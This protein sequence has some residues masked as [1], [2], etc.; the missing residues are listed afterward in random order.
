MKLYNYWRSSCSWRVRIALAY[1]NID[2]EYVAVHLVQAG[3]EQYGA[4]YRAINPMAEVP[5]LVFREGNRQRVLSQSL[6]IIEYLEEAY[7][8]PALLPSDPFDRATVRQ[9]A[10]VIHAGIQPLHNLVVLNHAA[11]HGLDKVEWAKHFIRRG[12]LALEQNATRTAGRVLVGDE[13]SIA[14]LC[15]VPQLAAARRFEV[16]LADC[17]TLQ[18]IEEYLS[19][20]AAF[21]AAHADKQID[22][23][24]TR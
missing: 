12:L 3:G 18:R 16:D 5:A 21:Q 23:P 10:H 8:T 2:Y 19:G 4:A 13:V 22:A 6:A 7:P 14:D 11:H 24:S 9:L 15:L 1:K 20:L 17:P